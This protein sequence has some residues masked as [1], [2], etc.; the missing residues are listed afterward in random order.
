MFLFHLVDDDEELAQ[1]YTECR[2]GTRMCGHCKALAAERTE[3]FLKEHQELREV[4]KDR[5]DEYGL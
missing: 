4:A 3:K 5:L 1:I 2:E